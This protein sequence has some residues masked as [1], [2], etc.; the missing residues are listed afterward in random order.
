M[1][2]FILY[3]KLIE[4]NYI[5]IYFGLNCKGLRIKEKEWLGIYAAQV[6]LCAMY[7]G[8]ANDISPVLH[9][10]VPLHNTVVVNEMFANSGLYATDLTNH[11]MA[12]PLKTVRAI[13][14][15]YLSE[16]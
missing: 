2:S 14:F 9:C 4:E 8:S 13:L 3:F 11:K 1:Q 12:V 10:F 6:V 16:F 15:T 5:Q 7:T